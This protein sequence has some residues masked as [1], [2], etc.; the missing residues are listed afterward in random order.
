MNEEFKLSEKVLQFSKDE[1]PVYNEEDVKEFIKR[2]KE[3]L[4]YRESLGIGRYTTEGIKEEIDKLA[5]SDLIEGEK[6]K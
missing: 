5:G 6:E 2:L 1:I 3:Y 4:D